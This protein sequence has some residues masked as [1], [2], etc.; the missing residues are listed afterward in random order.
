M[1]QGCKH[2]AFDATVSV[3]RLE[4]TGRFMAEIRIKCLDCGEPFQFLGLPMGLNMA[5]ATVDPD[6]LEARIAILPDS[7][8]LSPARRMMAKAEKSQ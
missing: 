4:D 2:M 1:T 8:T 5:G 6:G 7:Q 3:A